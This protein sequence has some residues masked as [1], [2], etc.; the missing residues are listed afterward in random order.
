MIVTMH[1]KAFFFDRERVKRAVDAAKLRVLSQIG[2]TIRKIVRHSIRQR[3][4]FNLA[5]PPGRP[6]YSHQGLL[7]RLILYGYDRGSDSVVVGP[8]GSRGSVVPNVLEFGGMSTRTSW[9]AVNHR[10][11]EKRVRIRPRPYMRPALAR[12]L[13]KIPD[14]W[15]GS[16]REG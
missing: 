9:D 10:I 13:P 2:G 8:V 14:R 4:N 3:E 12:E 5:S 6:P 15:R 11:V 7:R 1:L 16:V